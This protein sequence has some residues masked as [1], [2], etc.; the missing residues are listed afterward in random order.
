M[1]S[2]SGNSSTYPR[3]FKPLMRLADILW[4]CS[5]QP[6]DLSYTS[7]AAVRPAAAHRSGADRSGAN[8]DPAESAKFTALAQSWWDPHGPSR[9]LHE[10]NP[11][12]L[13]Y[14]E[15]AAASAPG[16]ARCSTSAAAAASS[17]SRWRAPA[18]GARHR[19][20]AAPCRGRRLHALEAGVALDYRTSR[21]RIWRASSRAPSI[22]HLHGDARARAGSGRGPRALAALAQPAR[23]CHRLDA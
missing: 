6:P 9:P 4:A 2:T 11:L 1:V 7:P 18:P 12:R 15:R 19:S 23:R 13:Q 22:G 17:P 8:A 20:C 10:L 3:Q 5:A 16:S 14:V 21:P